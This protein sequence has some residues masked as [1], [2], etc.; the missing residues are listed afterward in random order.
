M[1]VRKM[2]ALELDIKELFYLLLH[3][4]WIIVL[5]GCIGAFCTFAICK[6]FIKP[7]YTS[8]TSVYVIN[9]EEE[10]KTTFADIQTGTQL[11]KDYLILVKSRP[12]T[13]QV[14][15]KLGLDL[16]SEQLAKM[17]EVNTPQDTRILE[18][19]VN[20]KDAYL[21][22]KIADSIAEVSAQRMVSIME[23]KKVN[24]VEQASLPTQPSSPNVFMN[25]ILGGFVSIFI[26]SILIITLYLLNDSIRTSEDIERYLGI[27]TLGTIPAEDEY[28]K[29]GRRLKQ[30][31]VKAALAS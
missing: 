17:I 3:K 23:M 31:K 20:S 24:V 13:E 7:V 4:L 22:K 11:T 15:M 18:I 14:I 9:R 27:T 12:V 16:T 29:K 2:D 8:S 1:E 30:K 21:A 10:N 5:I 26:A 19:K 28:N 25:T 6:F